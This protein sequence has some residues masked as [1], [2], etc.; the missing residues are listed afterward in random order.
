MVKKNIQRYYLPSSN[1]TWLAGK[2]PFSMGIQ[3]ENHRSIS[4][5]FPTYFMTP[6]GKWDKPHYEYASICSMMSFVYPFIPG[7]L[8]H[9]INNHQQPLSR[10]YYYPHT[11]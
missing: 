3:R 2:V 9:D 5:G 7:S 6:K 1:Q 11:G 4:G 8:V 10:L